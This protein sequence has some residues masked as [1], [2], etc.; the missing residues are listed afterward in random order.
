MVTGP[1]AE[2]AGRRPAIAPVVVGAEALG[3]WV[4]GVEGEAVSVGLE[5]HSSCVGEVGCHAAR[6]D[7]TEQ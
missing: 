3:L 2:Q 1:A 4:D 7:M 6:T 5:P